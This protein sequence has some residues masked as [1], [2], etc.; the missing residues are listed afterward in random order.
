MKEFKL[1]NA[2]YLEKLGYTYYEDDGFSE[3]IKKKY[4]KND[5]ERY[6]HISFDR[7]SKEVSIYEARYIKGTDKFKED[8]YLNCDNCKLEYEEVISITKILEELGYKVNGE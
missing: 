4:V 3:F 8:R 1:K 2:K 5:I 7:Y 6:K